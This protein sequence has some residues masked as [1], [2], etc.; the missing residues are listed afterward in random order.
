MKKI[1]I[2]ILLVLLMLLSYYVVANG[3][4]IGDFEAYSY[5]QIKEQNTAIDNK[6]SNASK[7][8]S[9][10]FPQK[11]A[12]LTKSTKDLLTAKNNYIDRTTYSTEGQIAEA[13]ELESY[14]IELLQQ[15]VGKYKKQEGLANLTMN[16]TNAT[17]SS[18]SIDG[19][20]LYDINFTL[21]GM[22]APSFLFITDL[23]NDEILQFKIENFK[24]VPGSDENLVTTFTV[25]SVPININTL[26][27][28]ASSNAANGGTTNTTNTNTVNNNNTTTNTGTNTNPGTN[29]NTNK[30]D[31]ITDPTKW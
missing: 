21:N 26:S 2:G 22:Y 11:Q 9:A 30:A 24:M 20:K 18:T 29:T 19:R 15:K 28:A 31:D 14:E 1:L 17:A 25:K 10:D 7:L 3:V 4:H 5:I 27:S 8:T 12:E 23:E 13:N 16:I 6:I